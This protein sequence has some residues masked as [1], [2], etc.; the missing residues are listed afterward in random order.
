MILTGTATSG[1]SE[2]DNNGKEVVTSCSRYR[3]LPYHR[4]QFR[5]KPPIEDN[6]TKSCEY[7]IP[8]SYSKVYK[9]KKPTTT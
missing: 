4:M 9:W 7:F 5:I 6:M 3:A 1:Q 2:P 8:C